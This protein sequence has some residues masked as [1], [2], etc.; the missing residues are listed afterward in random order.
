MNKEF[1]EQS[2]LVLRILPFIDQNIFALKG[3]TAINFFYR[4]LPRLSV[5]IDL[6]YLPIEDRK[7]S[8]ESIHKSLSDF[9]SIVKS[10]GFNCIADKKYDGKTEIKLIISKDTIQIKLEP[11][12]II[13]G[14]VLGSEM[15]SL[16]NKV[17]ENLV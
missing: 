12:Y 15:R 7:I 16:S 10:K 17:T 9:Q 6:T 1:E 13:R 14:S 4:D 2:M 11:N 5:D 3:G 8:F